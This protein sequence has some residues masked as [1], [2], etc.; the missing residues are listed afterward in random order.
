[1]ARS[2]ETIS[3]P[4]KEARGTFAVV[5]CITLLGAVL[6]LYRLGSYGLWRDEAE[7]V[8]TAA[9][10]FPSG[11]AHI[12]S[13]D[14]HAPLYFHLL[15]FWLN[16]A[17]KS[18]FS[19]RL[20]SALCGII[21]VPLLYLAGREMFNRRVALLSAWIGAI[22]PLHV[23]CSRTTRM[24]ALL[25]LLG[26]L[27]MLFLYRALQKGNWFFWLA[28]LLSAVATMYTH[29]WGILWVGALSL[30]SF[31]QL[32]YERRP[33]SDWVAWV[34]AEIG[35]AA[36]FLPWLP[37]LWKQLGIQEAVMG[38]WL[39]KQS[40]IANT[41][42]LFNELTALA[43]PRGRPYLW[44]LLLTLGTFS[45]RAC[46]P[47]FSQDVES[48]PEL[49]ISYPITLARNIVVL[50]LF[51]PMLLGSLLLARAHGLT[52][53]YV[54]MAV[55]PALCLLLALGITS[56]Q[57][58]WLIFATTVGLS[59]L[60]L[61]ADFSFYRGPISLLR[62]VAQY[63]DLYAD[64][65]DVIVVAPDYLA[66]TFSYYFQ[67]QQTQIA[68]PWLFRRVETMDWIG[69]AERRKRAAEAVPATLNYI[70]QQLGP[71][72]KVWLIAP[73]EAYPNDPF[74]D[75]IRALKSELDQRYR[76][77]QAIT[78]FRGAVE[79][80]DILVYETIAR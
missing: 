24:Y 63:V 43:W 71:R 76:L 14:V 4:S 21:T 28:Y 77:L 62:E 60:W 15:H 45:F 19:V 20:F 67:G 17:G 32:L 72:G 48:E 23:I 5:L 10:D 73:L 25:P 18:E 78:D 58:W 52:P 13:G 49:E 75:Q 69:W 1:M 11:I 56:L 39:P 26:L 6:R 12:L 40:K 54:T 8:F 51:T 50:G 35:I 44:M 74:F 2:R 31:L 3:T 22:L 38:P 27:A 65:Q 34:L 36:L 33:R 55:L 61:R 47:R 41:L 46:W 59:L 29:Y 16:L 68:F 66:P 64:D 79:T 70:A 30:C 37:T 9:A 7:A 53:S 80:A 42:R 57:R